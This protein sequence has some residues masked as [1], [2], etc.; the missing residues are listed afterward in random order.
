[1]TPPIRSVQNRQI[2]ADRKQV[3]GRQGLGEDGVGVTANGC[4][5]WGGA[6]E[7]VLILGSDYCTTV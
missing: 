6:D 4:G 7:K 5:V 2:H 1:M 3:I